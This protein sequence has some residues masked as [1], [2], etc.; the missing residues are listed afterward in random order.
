MKEAICPLNG[1]RR[2][3]GGLIKYLDEPKQQRTIQT[4]DV[5]LSKLV[6]LRPGEKIL[7]ELEALEISDSECVA[8]SLTVKDGPNKQ[9]FSDL[10][11]RINSTTSV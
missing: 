4:K 11:F 9:V 2:A 10:T 7:V 6:N 1:Q 5:T 8:C 3:D